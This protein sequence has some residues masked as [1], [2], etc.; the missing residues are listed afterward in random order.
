MDW[1]ECFDKK[2]VKNVKSD[3]DMINSLLKSSKN[4]LK[5]EEKLVMDDVTSGS[6][7]SLTYDSLRELLE[8]LA[9]KQ[10]YKIYNHECYTAF[11]K[12]IV[13]ESDK[14]DEFDEIRRIRNDINY[15]GKDISIEEAE[16]VIK[17]IRNLGQ[18]I[19]KLLKD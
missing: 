5:S 7:I 10:G 3:L 14:G 18:F 8:A 9:L 16:D 12:E 15:Y 17:R 19:L 13:K 4:K 2:I 6:K 1:I 11:L